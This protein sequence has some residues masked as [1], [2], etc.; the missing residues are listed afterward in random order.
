MKQLT[1][2]T[3]MEKQVLTSLIDGLYAEA[4]FSDVDA[5]DLSKA[6]NIPTKS[7]RGVISSLVKKGI[8]FVEEGGNG[9][10]EL[11]YLTDSYIGLHPRWAVE[12]NVEPIEIV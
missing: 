4:G 8:C 11:I 7:I 5:K 6:T 9:M 2:L 12:E 1:N 3:Q 10:F